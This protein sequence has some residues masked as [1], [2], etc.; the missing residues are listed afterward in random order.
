MSFF[1]IL[2]SRFSLQEYYLLL[3][4]S[5]IYA[6]ACTTQFAFPIIYKEPQ[7]LCFDNTSPNNYSTCY[8][9]QVCSS[10]ITYKIN[11]LGPKSLSAQFSLICDKRL[12]KSTSLTIIFGVSLLGVFFNIITILSPKWR[13]NFYSFCGIIIGMSLLLSVHFSNNLNTVSFFLGIASSGYIL[14]LTYSFLLINDLFED[15]TAKVSFGVLNI[16][17]GIFGVLYTLIGWWTNAD[18]KI[19]NIITGI[20]I[21]ISSVI[22]NILEEDQEADFI[23]KTSEMM[24]QEVIILRKKK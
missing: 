4:I 17:W 1:I 23:V 8:E 20:I 3:C 15:D 14:I 6:L 7:L 2:T 9:K 24:I 5:I 12:E 10:N 19:L 18:W 22:L 16:C 21:M 13:K 11:E